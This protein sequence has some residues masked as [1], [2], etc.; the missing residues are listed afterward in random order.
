MIEQRLQPRLVLH[1]RQCHGNHIPDQMPE[2]I[3]VL[4]NLTSGRR[5]IPPSLLG[6]QPPHAVGVPAA[7]TIVLNPS[8]IVLIFR[9]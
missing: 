1:P 6:C 7:S 5:R 9:S 3:D 2:T 8:S 4:V